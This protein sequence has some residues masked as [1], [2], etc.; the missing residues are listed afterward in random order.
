[1]E[2]KCKNICFTDELVV[3]GWLPGRLHGQMDGS[4]GNQEVGI[5]NPPNHRSVILCATR[6]TCNNPV[7]K[8]KQQINYYIVDVIIIAFCL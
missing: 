4:Q 3:S 2:K 8:L 6:Q 7:T 5:K 1:M